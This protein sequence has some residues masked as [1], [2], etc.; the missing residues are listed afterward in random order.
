MQFDEGQSRVSGTLY[1]AGQD[2]CKLLNEVYSSFSHTNPMHS[3][4]FPSVRQMESEVIAMTAAMLGGN[5][6]S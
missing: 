3:D 6:P 1:M 5:I 4:V 2:H